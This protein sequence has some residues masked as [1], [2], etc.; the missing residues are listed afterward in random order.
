MKKSFLFSLLLLFFFNPILSQKG[1]IETYNAEDKGYFVNPVETPYGIVFS[2][3]YASQIYLLTKKSTIKTIAASPGC[4]RYFTISPDKTKVGFKLIN[5]LGQQTPAFYNLLKN[6]TKKIHSPENK[7]GQLSFSNSK[8][9]FSIN[10]DFFLKTDK[11]QKIFKNISKTDIAPISP[12]GKYIIY[13]VKQEYFILYNLKNRTKNKIPNNGKGVIYPK[14]SPD[15]KKILFQNRNMELFVYDLETKKLHKIGKGGAGNWNKNSEKIIFHRKK[16]DLDNFVLKSSEIFISDYKGENIF[17]LTNTP[18]IYEMTPSFDLQ[19]GII[20]QTYDKRQI[21]RAKLNSTGNNIISKKIL[22]D[23]PKDI[24]PKHYDLSKFSKK[25]SITHLTNPVPYVHQLY[26][27]PTGRN[28]NAACAPTTSTMALAY[29]NRLPKWPVAAE[30]YPSVTGSNHTCDYSGYVLDR[31]KYNEHSFDAYSSSKNAYGGYAYMWV[32]PYTSPGSG[33]MQGFQNHHDMISGNYVWL[34]N[35]TFQKTCDEIDNQYPHSICSWITHSGHLTLAVGYVNG[36][37]TVIFN[38]PWGNKNTAGYP[39]YD[40]LDSYYDWPGWNNGYQNLD[41]DGSHGTVAWTLTARS[42]EPVYENLTIENIYYNHGFYMNNSEDGAT[43]RYYRHVIDGAGHSGHIWWTGGVGGAASDICWVK[44]TPDLPGAATYKVEVYIPAPF[45]DSYSSAEVTNSAHY[46]IYYDGGN[47]TVTV[48]Q[49]NNQGTWVDLGNYSFSQ[50]ENG[51]VYLGDAVNTSDDGKKLLFDAVKFTQ[52]SASLQVD[53]TNVTCK[54]SDDGTATVS[55]VPG[56]SPHTY[57]WSH[58]PG[59]NTNS[60]T[61]LSPGDYTITVTDGNSD[62]YE[63]N[64]TIDEADIALTLSTSST[65]PTTV[66]GSNGE[67]IANISGGVEPYD[68]SWS[69]DPSNNSNTASNLSAGDYTVT[70]IDAYNCQLQETVTLYDPECCTLLYADFSGGLPNDW[71]NEVNSGGYSTYLWRFDDPENR[72]GSGVL[73]GAGFDSNFAIF[74]DDYLGDNGNKSDASLTTKAVDCS[75][76]NNIFLQFSHRFRHSVAN[77]ATG[78]LEVSNNGTN[79]T[80]LES[81]SAS[82]EGPIVRS[83]DISAY[84]ANQSTVYV[85]WTYTDNSNWSNYW[86]IDNVEI[87][88]PLSGTYTVKTDGSGD[89]G[90]LTDAVNDLNNCGVGTGGVTFLVEAED[91]FEEELPV[92]TATGTST[93]EIIFQTS[94]PNLSNP[95]LKS[96]GTSGSNDAAI[97]IAGGDYITFDGIDI[98]AGGN[99]LEH[100]FY[101]YNISGN[102]GAQN[103]TFKNLS[104]TLDRTNENTKAIYQYIQTGTINP[105]SSDGSNSFNKYQ[106]LAISDTYHGIDLYGYDVSGQEPLY[107]DGCQISYCSIYDFGLTGANSDRA[108]GVLTW[109]QKN[110]E[111]HHNTVHSGTSAHRTLGIYCAGNN[112]ASI[113]NNTIYDLYG[114]DI[115]VVGIRE[116]QSDVSIYLNEIFNIEG[117]LMASGIEGY[118]GTSYI[119]NNYIYDI[120]APNG[121]STLNGYPSA[122]GISFRNTSGTQS[123]F[124]NTVYLAYYSSNSG[125]E[126]TCLYLENSIAD[127]RNNIFENNTDASTGTR[128]NVLYFKGASDLSN[129][130]TNTDHN[131]YYNGVATTKYALAYDDANSTNYL[132]LTDYQ[133]ASPNDVNSIEEN[134]PF[135]STTE[136]YDLHIDVTQSSNI[137]GGAI[138]IS[139]ITE[140]FDGDSRDAISPDIGADEYDVAGALCGTYTIDNTLATSGNNFNNFTDAINALNNRGISCSVIFN[141]AADQ[142]FAEDP[143]AIETSGTFTN[144]VTFQKA[145]TGNNPVIKPSGSPDNDNDY[146]IYIKGGDYF[147][148]D[149]IDVEIQTG[150]ELEYGYYLTNIS[151]TDGARYNTIKNCTVTLNKNNTNSVGVYQLIL[152]SINP[153][154]SEGANSFNL[155]ENISINNVY[156]GFKIFGYDVSGQEALYDDG[157]E[158][159]SSSVNNFG[160]QNLRAVG[161]LTWSQKNL[162]FH[163]NTISN[164]SSPTYVSGNDGR[165]LGIYT[166]GNNSGDVYNNTI[167]ALQGVGAQ[168]VG[169]RAYES[170][171]DFYNNEVYNIEGVDMAS[172]IEIYGGTSY[173]YNNFVRDIKTP[174]TESYNYPTTR[175]ISNRKGTAYIYNNSVLLN[176]TS[177]AENNESAG[178]FTEGFSYGSAISDIRNNIVVN[179]TDVSTGAVAAALYKSAE[180]STI[181]TNS[182]NNLYYAGSFSDKSFIFYDTNVGDQTIEDYKARC[183]TYEQNSISEDAPFVSSNDL[184]IQTS[185]ITL[186]DCGGQSITIVSDDFDSE[187]RNPTNPDIGADEFECDFIVWRGENDTDWSKSEN[188]R[189][190]QVPTITDNVIIPDVSTES[191]NF[192]IITDAAE[193]N[194]L[195]IYSGAILKINPD[196]SLTVNGTMTNNAGISGFIIKSNNNGTGSFINSTAN[197]PAT[198][199]RYLNGTQWHYLSPPIENAP[200][201]LFN[202]NNFYYYDE[203]VEDSWSGGIF[204][205]DM[206]WTT[207]TNTTLN[208][209]EGYAYYFNETTIN[210]EG[211]LHTGTFTSPFLTWTDT[212]ADNQY[213][214]WHLLGNPYPSAI[215]WDSPDINFGGIDQTVYFYDDNIDN[216]RYYNTTTGGNNGGTQYI[217]AMQGFFVH[218]GTNNTQLEFN[219]NS[220]VHNTTNFYKNNNNFILDKPFIKLK[221]TDSILFDETKIVEISDASMNFNGQYDAY[222]MYSEQTD[223]PFIYTFYENEEFAI[224]AIPQITENLIISLGFYAKNSGIYNL[225]LDKETID[226]PIFLYDKQENLIQNLN[227]NNT[228]SFL[229]SGGGAKNRFEIRFKDDLK[230]TKINQS[231]V[232]IYPNPA[233]DFFKFYILGNNKKIEKIKIFDMN[234]KLIENISS[235][236]NNIIDVSTYKPGIYFI[237]IRLKNS[238]FNDK[239]IIK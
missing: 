179:K 214:G 93:R 126:S 111:I 85:R 122:R 82:T 176:Y 124:Y 161:I 1:Q 36:Q 47:T 135:K 96:Y 184:H 112:T 157:T 109:S 140:D 196:Y 62:T 63:E 123:V 49:K 30:N 151:E 92:I 15:S 68:I 195:T 173:I 97:E 218:T 149:G 4:G 207:Y 181:S 67:I 133:A 87:Y 232:L 219:N 211:N 34:S 125:N 155:Y 95:V 74:D 51:Y 101:L 50:G 228:Y 224:N 78:K 154:S 12:D 183:I 76:K 170:E 55:S 41:P 132:D 14:W 139:G 35:A 19:E 103:N 192:P 33:G 160:G 223:V 7:C 213:E 107:D 158:I 167:Y 43:Q 175:G 222:K 203:T 56:P 230:L 118:G 129:L 90:S 57:S 164:G 104:I 75:G 81:W 48:D 131:C 136:P 191:N 120:K 45:T 11:N 77:P 142:A 148:F 38:D 194:N 108:T 88:A 46:K 208:S 169:I 221:S 110:L 150:S 134:P 61:G 159:S 162:N 229:H 121:N 60:A 204:S 239:I 198:V 10:D 5:N 40:G 234:G 205:D 225:I 98:I 18:D 199:Q 13:D 216:Y 174:A 146:G 141:V 105:A 6:K 168:V 153:S 65:N 145:G 200:L 52:I 113:H 71:T 238:F 235:S 172:G 127:L 94:N 8:F 66:G 177:T 182:D 188:W 39:S 152:N 117:V 31:Y 206:G 236:N 29:Y 231:K 2:D 58:D 80:L 237:K 190:K 73:N 130:S 193:V 187:P 84:A 185:A 210:F 20:Y 24:K 54:G 220:R 26:D 202:T 64:F 114:E 17:Q 147:T 44:W 100:G 28:G 209:M 227:K 197:V 99:N 27:A 226:L 25:K 83:Y 42:S 69:H 138:S 72:Y 91:I 171:T 215:D 116:Y 89:Y 3:N 144:T 16:V 189:K 23:N 186:I 9:C 217:P 21:I 137:N 37:H 201:S 119:Y 233:D 165:C 79:W 128:A 53:I 32:S 106:N 180:Y 212:P 156:H 163:N 70:V 143:P 59:N 115:Q 86:A 178:I 102:N 22:L 166:A